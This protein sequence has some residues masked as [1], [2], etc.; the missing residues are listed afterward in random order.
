VHGRKFVAVGVAAA[1]QTAWFWC[2]AAVRSILSDVRLVR[3][4]AMVIT[5]LILAMA[6][7]AANVETATSQAVAGSPSTNPA[8]WIFPI[9][10]PAIAQQQGWKGTVSFVLHYD[11]R[12]KPSRCEVK[13]TSGHQLLD[14]L[15]CDILMHR[16][17][18]HPGKD[19][20]GAAVGGFYR[21]RVRWGA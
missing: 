7:P 1:H 21:N 12:G 11:E 15:T 17:S 19:E 4:K 9:D 18:F 2:G 16:A 6:L 10:Y 14:V 5:A 20:T 3:G 13:E 8:S